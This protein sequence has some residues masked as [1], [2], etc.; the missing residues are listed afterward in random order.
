MMKPNCLTEHQEQALLFSWA[1]MYERQYP[2]LK[3]MYSVPNGA[4]MGGDSPQAKI[5]GIQRFNKLKKEGLKQGMPDICLPCA[6]QGYHGLYIELKRIKGGTVSHEQKEWL[7]ALN[8]E[9]YK[10]VVCRGFDEA[11]EVIEEYLS[12]GE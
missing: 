10:A 12:I 4:F 2:A 1:A 3:L 8:S 6:R 5:R 9:G 7:A 11:R